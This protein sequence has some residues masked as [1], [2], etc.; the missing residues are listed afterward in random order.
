MWP[1]AQVF[2]EIVTKWTKSPNKG[3]FFF[4]FFCLSPSP[5][6]PTRRKAISRLLADSRWFYSSLLWSQQGQGEGGRELGASWTAL[7]PST[8]RHEEME[9]LRG[10]SSLFCLWN[11]SWGFWP[12]FQPLTGLSFATWEF[13]AR[14]ISSCHKKPCFSPLVS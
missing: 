5:P 8:N 7:R 14:K 12:F 4:F 9:L 10:W 3:T 13:D 11:W 6:S 1:D 2:I